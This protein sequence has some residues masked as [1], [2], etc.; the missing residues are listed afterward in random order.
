VDGQLAGTWY[1]AGVSSKVGV[2]GHP[3]CWRDEDFPLPPS[4]TREKAF[5]KVS[6]RFIPTNNPQNSAWTASAYQMYDFILP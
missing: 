3:R 6:L 1:D 5:V 4:L 2:D